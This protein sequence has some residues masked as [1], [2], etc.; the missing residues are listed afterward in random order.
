MK[1]QMILKLASIIGCLAVVF[2][3]FGA[4]SFESILLENNR[5]DTFETAVQY[6][7]YHV[8][9]LVLI[10]ILIQ[11]NK[12][13]Y[14]VRSAYLLIVGILLFSGSLYVLALTNITILGAITPIGGLCF[15]AGWTCLFY[16]AKDQKLDS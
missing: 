10:S 1:P 15:I 3:A 13:I 5:V 16:S 2:G 11:K 12:S 8:I 9:I 4:H 6:H 7:F 14:L